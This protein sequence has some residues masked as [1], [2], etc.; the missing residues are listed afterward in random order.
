MMFSRRHFLSVLSAG[1]LA[2]TLDLDKL[3][4]VPGRKAF[5]LPPADRV[6][7]DS[8]FVSLH[9]ADP[10]GVGAAEAT[11]RNYARVTVPRPARLQGWETTPTGIIAMPQTRIDFP[12]CEGGVNTITHF[13]I[14]TVDGRT[15]AA[16]PLLTRVSLGPHTSLRLYASVES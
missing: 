4:W 11:Y 9:T 15:L 2:S 1:A 5:F 3:L 12:Q 8:L 7:T 16:G 10:A 14:R 13:A 6:F